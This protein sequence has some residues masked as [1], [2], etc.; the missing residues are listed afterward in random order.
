L[1]NLR[2]G[3]LPDRTRDAL[4]KRSA[5]IQGDTCIAFAP[6]L[7]CDCREMHLSQ[8]QRESAN[9][10]RDLLATGSVTCI[11]NGTAGSNRAISN[12]ERLTDLFAGHGVESSILLARN[13]RELAALARRA[14]EENGGSLSLPA[15]TALSMRSPAL[16][17]APRAQWAYCLSARSTIS[18]RI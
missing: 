1:E 11:L 9:K 8:E 16:W 10:R 15:A 2:F 14:I 3:P 4:A 13:G 6:T 12:R 7:L 5:S 17:S 18:P